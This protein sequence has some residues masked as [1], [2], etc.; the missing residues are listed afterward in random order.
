MVFPLSLH[1]FLCFSL[2]LCLCLSLSLIFS[3]GF[4]EFQLEHDFFFVLMSDF[5]FRVWI[6]FPLPHTEK[7]AVKLGS[8]ERGK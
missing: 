5:H 4:W 2:C 6:F 3:T 1:S 8:L 7:Q